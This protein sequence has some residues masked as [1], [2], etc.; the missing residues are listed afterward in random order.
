MSTPD[1]TCLLFV[2]LTPKA[3]EE[4]AFNQWYETEDIPAFVRD[5][6]GI[7][8]C[9]RFASLDPDASGTRTSLTIYEFAD[10]AAL[11]RGLEVMRSRDQWRAAWKD[12]EKRAVASISDNLFRTTV[13]IAGSVRS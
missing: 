9:R 3:E 13:S 1:Q 2:Q 10:E 6:P 12:W 4:A 5:V 11:R 8:R 7:V